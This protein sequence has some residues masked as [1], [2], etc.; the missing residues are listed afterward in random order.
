MTHYRSTA[1]SG[2]SLAGFVGTLLGTLRLHPR[3]ASVVRRRLREIAYRQ[4]CDSKLAAAWAF[5]RQTNP[6]EAWF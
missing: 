4:P 2:S 6:A 5:Q 3:N 1:T